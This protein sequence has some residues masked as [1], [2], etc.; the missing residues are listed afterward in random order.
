MKRHILALIIVTGIAVASVTSASWGAGGPGYGGYGNCPQMMGMQPPDQAT[1]DK[2]NKFFKDNQAL[3]KQI[4]MKQAEM[5]ALMRNE[6][7]DPQAASKVAG[8]L[9]DLRTAFHDK[10]EVAGVAQFVG[11]MGPGMGMG[12]GRGMHGMRGMRGG[13]PGMMGGP[14]DMAPA[15]N[16]PVQQ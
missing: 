4:V 16:A 14:A 8:E 13:M 5:H 10:A 3:H 9:F 6:K 1:R 15:P 7:T 12:M 11:P 2:L